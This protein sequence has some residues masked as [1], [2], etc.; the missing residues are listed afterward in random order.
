MPKTK[1]GFVLDDREMPKNPTPKEWTDYVEIHNQMIKAA[2]VEA[3]KQDQLSDTKS[4]TI[5]E[6]SNKN[7]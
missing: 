5:P 4:A 3:D 6:R 7:G 1:N 2:L